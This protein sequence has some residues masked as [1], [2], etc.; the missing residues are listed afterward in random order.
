MGLQSLCLT[1]IWTTGAHSA[2]VTWWRFSCCLLN[3]SVNLSKPADIIVWIFIWCCLFCFASEMEASC[4]QF[5][6]SSCPFPLIPMT[7]M[8]LPVRLI[9]TASKA[10]WTLLPSRPADV[11]PTQWDCIFWNQDL[12]L[13]SPSYNPKVNPCC[14]R[15]KPETLNVIYEV[16]YG[17][18]CLPGQVTSSLWALRRLQPLHTWCLPTPATLPVLLP[19]RFSNKLNNHY[20]YDNSANI[21]THTHTPHTQPC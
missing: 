13:Y 1:H 18:P 9:S 8:P 19:Y 2:V 5:N 14:S 6:L 12:V 20:I 4:G 15:M 16:L 3:L 21:Q 11:L 7:G 17:P 10:S